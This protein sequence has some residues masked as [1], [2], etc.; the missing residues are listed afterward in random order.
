MKTAVLASTMILACAAGALGSG[1][2]E[3]TVRESG[4]PEFITPNDEYYVTRIGEV[5]RIDGEAYRLEI[6]GLVASPRSLSLDE[7]YAMELVELPLT[8]EC[9]GNS[10]TSADFRSS[11]IRDFSRDTRSASSSPG[12]RWERSSYS[13]STPP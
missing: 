11:S 1:G 4:F 3:P 9:I 7:L 6:S 13:A 12:C 5:P 2:S 10:P 8:V